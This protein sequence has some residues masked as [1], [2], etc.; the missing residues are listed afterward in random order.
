MKILKYC[1]WIPFLCAFSTFAQPSPGRDIAGKVINERGEPLAN[2]NVTI[3]NGRGTVTNARGQFLLKNMTPND[4]LQI[5]FAGYS[6]QTV[7]VKE[8]SIF[9]I[10]LK[11]AENE[12][13]RVV[14]QGYGITSDR[15]RTGSIVKV[16]AEQIS[17]QPAMNVLNVLQ[18]QAVIAET[19]QAVWKP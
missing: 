15:L 8:Q 14:V 7:A 2:A 9:N 18:G 5:S 11:Q 16:T 3:K 4:I 1:L 19:L 17:K 10:V 13:D 12:L 6:S